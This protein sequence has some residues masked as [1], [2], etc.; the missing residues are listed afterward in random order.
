MSV[1]TWVSIRVQK[2]RSRQGSNSSDADER[3]W[4]DC[5][6]NPHSSVCRSA[7]V[8]WGGA[9]NTRSPAKR[10]T[11]YRSIVSRLPGQRI[12][13]GTHGASRGRSL[14]AQ[15]FEDAR[16][17][18]PYS[19]CRAGID[20]TIH[21]TLSHE[22]HVCIPRATLSKIGMCWRQIAQE[23]LRNGVGIWIDSRL[24][25]CEPLL[26]PIVPSRSLW[27]PTSGQKTA[28]RNQWVQGR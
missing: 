11:F 14:T 23:S 28:G 22:D 9:S 1:Q 8:P 12:S 21:V 5:P 15:S 26:T 4:H 2:H 20:A 10:R 18:L 24:I 3:V 7:L 19:L 6:L 17:S 25:S 13:L 16:H 27:P